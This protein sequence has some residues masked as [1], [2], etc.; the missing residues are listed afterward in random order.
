MVD[1]YQAV[2]GGQPEPVLNFAAAD[3]FTGINIRTV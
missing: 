2:S 3:F 1:R